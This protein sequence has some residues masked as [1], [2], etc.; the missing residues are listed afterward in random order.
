VVLVAQTNDEGQ[1]HVGVVAGRGV[2]TAVKRNRAKRLMRAAMQS[3][4]PSV[5]VGWDVLLIARRALV[6]SD[7][8]EVRQALLTLLRRAELIVPA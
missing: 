3:L 7:M 2:G 4:V 8:F 1:V 5:A 6:S